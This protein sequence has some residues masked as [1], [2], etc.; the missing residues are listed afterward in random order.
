MTSS[1]LSLRLIALFIK[2]TGSTDSRAFFKADIVI[3]N[4]ENLP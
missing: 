1:L 3:L 4:E 2:T